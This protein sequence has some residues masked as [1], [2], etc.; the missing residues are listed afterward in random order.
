MGFS[1]TRAPNSVGTAD[2]Y[3]PAAGA[4]SIEKASGGRGQKYLE[5]ARRRLVHYHHIDKSVELGGIRNCVQFSPQILTLLSMILKIYQKYP[6]F[7]VDRYH[8]KKHQESKT[9]VP[10]T[11]KHDRQN[12]SSHFFSG[13]WIFRPLFFWK[14]QNER[15]ER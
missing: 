12:F 11:L 10:S 3:F 5:L 7:T 2:D 6:N 8:K 1:N 14:R 15:R 9:R 4:F 13:N